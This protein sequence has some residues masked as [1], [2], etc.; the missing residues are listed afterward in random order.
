MLDERY[1][2]AATE[3]KERQSRTG[4]MD[5]Y[6]VQDLCRI[7]RISRPTVY[8]LLRKKQFSWVNI[9]GHK[10]RI[11]RKSFDEWLNNQG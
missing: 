6:S 8:S 7:L 11:S 9:G 3:G 2:K 4:G 10:Y 5:C 1:Y